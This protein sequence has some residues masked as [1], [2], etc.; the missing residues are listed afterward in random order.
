[1]KGGTDGKDYQVTVT[2][3]LNTGSLAYVLED[4]FLVQVQAV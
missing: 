4:D 1:V 2:A 3:T